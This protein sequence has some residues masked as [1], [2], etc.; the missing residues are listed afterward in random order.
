MQLEGYG[1]ECICQNGMMIEFHDWKWSG[2]SKPTIFYYLI[3]V[4]VINYISI[5]ICMAGNEFDFLTS[6][7]SWSNLTQ[8]VY[9]KVNKRGR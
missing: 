7:F 5:S 1:E 4:V 3:G 8:C 2:G 9:Y 6:Y